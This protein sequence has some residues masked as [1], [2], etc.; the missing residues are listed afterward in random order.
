MTI[1]ALNNEDRKF[2]RDYV[3]SGS[4]DE[5]K[6]QFRR[7]CADTFNVSI[8]TIA[9]ITAWTKI[10]AKRLMETDATQ[11]PLKEEEV[12][13]E[14]KE[15]I[16]EDGK[17]GSTDED[18]HEGGEH[19]DYDNEIKRAWR[20]KIYE[21]VDKNTDPKKRRKMRVLCL[22]GK[23]CLEIQTYLDLGFRSQNIL[24]VEGGDKEARDE[25]EENAKRMGIQYQIGR[26]EKVLEKEKKP[27]DVVSLD[28][29]GAMCRG[30]DTV[31]KML[32]L[33]DDA[34][35]LLNTRARRE[36]I[37]TKTEYLFLK[38]LGA[39]DDLET[40]MKKIG[41]DMAWLESPEAFDGRLESVRKAFIAKVKEQEKK[42]MKIDQNIRDK[43][44]TTKA[45]NAL[46][47]P[48]DP[49]VA[50]W[51]VKVG[52][53]L[54][55]KLSLPVDSLKD[56]DIDMIRN[57]MILMLAFLVSALLEEAEN[58]LLESLEKE[59]PAG[60]LQ[61]G[62]ATNGLMTAVIQPFIIAVSGRPIFGDYKRYV[63]TS[64]G[65]TRTKFLSE[66]VSC[67][68]MR[69]IDKN[70]PTII[71]FFQEAVETIIEMM[72]EGLG[73]VDP[74]N[75]M[76]TFLGSISESV[77][78]KMALPDRKTIM[79]VWRCGRLNISK[80]NRWIEKHS[81]YVLQRKDGRKISKINVRQLRQE[82]EW[83][84]NYLSHAEVMLTPQIFQDRELVEE[85]FQEISADD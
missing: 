7:E 16:E 48:R 30:Y 22:P 23:K 51:S 75:L 67:K 71:R 18:P 43:G 35:I 85:E 33:S 53:A 83:F 65:K 21:F 17:Y 39:W 2:I 13:V 80:L 62:N 10:R 37:T 74:G 4:T 41:F 14:M 55:R 56:E 46:Q 32:P 76:F 24:G 40:S 25:F 34:I 1:P 63:Y 11:V 31:M 61:N 44:V 52:N 70:C 57:R 77:D 69:L 36:N 12:S 50:A 79:D 66:F 81:N 58:K 26:L 45:V 59:N 82:A 8:Q 9:A 78:A 29:L 15:D 27:F 68:S 54:F 19:F 28:F 38:E 20:R 5:E 84:I 6:R 3:S 73:N 64:T 72:P 49:S 42:G 60:A 47:M